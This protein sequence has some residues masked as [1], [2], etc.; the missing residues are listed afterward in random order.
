M[1]LSDLPTVTEL[2]TAEPEFECKSVGFQNQAEKEER[3]FQVKRRVCIKAQ[4][5]KKY[6]HSRCFR[7]FGMA[8]HEIGNNRR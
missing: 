6:T 1:K 5:A 8:K 2:V 7:Q 4:T 3:A